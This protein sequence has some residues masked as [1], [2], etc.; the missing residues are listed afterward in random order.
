M[1]HFRIMLLP[2]VVAGC[3]TQPVHE[4]MGYQDF[5]PPQQWITP[6]F[7][8]TAM[9]D[10]WGLSASTELRALIERALSNNPNQLQAALRVAEADAL[11]RIQRGAR[12]PTL[13][14]TA[15]HQSQRLN[16]STGSTVSG[17]LSSRWE[18]DVWQRLGDVAQASELSADAVGAD[19]AAARL[20]LAA[21]VIR[22]VLSIVS[23]DS[24]LQIEDR[25]LD[26]LAL[27]ERFIRERYLAGLGTLSDLEAARTALAQ[28]RANV[29]ARREDQAANRRAL[30]VLLGQHVS[31]P[32]LPTELSIE[33]P[34][35]AL[36]ATVIQRRPD[37]AAA[38]SRVGAADLE[39]HAAAKALLPGLNL[40]FDTSRAGNSLGD[41]LDADPV[42]TLVA[43]L[44]APVFRGGQLRAERDR[45][46]LA[47]ERAYWAY[48]EALL[49]ALLEVEDSLGQEAALREQSDILTRAITFAERN[50][51][52][53]ESRYRD[54][55][56]NIFDLLDAQQTAF[57]TQIDLLDTRLARDINRVDMAVAMGLGL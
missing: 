40:T 15:N 9:E 49:Q 7:D 30:A 10:L 25:R 31:T 51:R 45:A 6:A 34:D 12:W 5:Q 55:L 11:A 42:T 27:N 37:L 39:A 26:T 3:V 41:L 33:L 36:P 19:Y 18:V 13:D 44:A 4:P 29:T 23:S 17:M 48:R 21:S 32:E 53:F 56:A 54:G 52:I 1:G 35:T 28:R 38:L 43:S 50:R 16:G 20:S 2:L 24:I 22:S 47:A 8:S 14:A 57:D 46:G